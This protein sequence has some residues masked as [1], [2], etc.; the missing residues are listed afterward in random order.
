MNAPG[1]SESSYT[2]TSL[3]EQHVAPSN[4]SESVQSQQPF[5]STLHEDDQVSRASMTSLSNSSHMNLADF[6][7]IRY[8]NRSDFADADSDLA[9]ITEKKNGRD[10]LAFLEHENGTVF[11]KSEIKAVGKAVYEVFQT[12]LDDGLAPKTWSQ[13]SS[14]ATN[15]LRTD[16]FA[17]FPDIRLC[18]NNW[19]ADTL[20]SEK[21]AQWTRRRKDEIS[22]SSSRKLEKSSKPV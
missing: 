10:K 19:K 21:Y 2:A 18:A 8:W 3:P 7:Q 14:R 20:A 12:L 16:L 6:A 15:I 13:A 4:H 11:S 9:E 17:K 1:P 5:R 22:K